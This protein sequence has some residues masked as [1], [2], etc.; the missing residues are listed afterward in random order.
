[1]NSAEHPDY[2]PKKGVIRIQMFQALLFWS[3]GEDCR[4][5][6]FQTFNMGGYFP[7]R[8]LNMAIGSIMKKQMDSFY[9]KIQ[10]AEKDRLAEVA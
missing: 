10:Q 7:M 1:M 9:P 5:I 2:P 4:A 8:L 3:E 6:Q